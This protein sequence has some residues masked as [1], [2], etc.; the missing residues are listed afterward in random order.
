MLV[1]GMGWKLVGNGYTVLLVQDEKILE[2]VGQNVN[3]FNP[4]AL[5]T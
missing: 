3:I 1:G 2:S 5:Y 4:A